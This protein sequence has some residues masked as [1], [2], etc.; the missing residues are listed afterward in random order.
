MKISTSIKKPTTKHY[1]IKGKDLDTLFANLEA[2]AFWGRFVANEA[3]NWGTKDPV[4]KVTISAK[5]VIFMPKWTEYSKADKDAKTRF[6]KMYKALAKHENNHFYHLLEQV[7]IF[8]ARLD[9]METLSAKDAKAEW[10]TF[11]AD[12]SKAQK[13]YDDVTN[14]GIKEGVEL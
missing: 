10:K 11:L 1:N 4:E 13:K 9:G 6:D 3:V 14:H 7:A 8:V 2:R 5:P 12:H